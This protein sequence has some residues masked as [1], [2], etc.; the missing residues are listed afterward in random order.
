M[1][2]SRVCPLPYQTAAMSPS[3]LGYLWRGD[4]LQCHLERPPMRFND[5]R[6]WTRLLPCC[7][8]GTLLDPVLAAVGSRPWRGSLVRGVA[9]LIGV[10]GGYAPAAVTALPRRRP[11]SRPIPNPIPSPISM[12][13]AG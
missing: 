2:P 13:E 4:R 1:P 9:C 3:R 12:D 7:L 10:S 5:S 11:T 6:L 8:V